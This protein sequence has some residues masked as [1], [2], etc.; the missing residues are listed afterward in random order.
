METATERLKLIVQAEIDKDPHPYAADFGHDWCDLSQQEAL[1][2]SL[3]P[4][5]LKTLVP[6]WCAYEVILDICDMIDIPPDIVRGFRTENPWIEE[7]CKENMMAHADFIKFAALFGIEE[8]KA[9][10]W[11]YK[12]IFWHE[13]EKHYDDAETLDEAAIT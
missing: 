5:D 6:V 1:I 3:D 10:A 8:R 12:C 4:D 11:F 13:R 7:H 2:F 9:F